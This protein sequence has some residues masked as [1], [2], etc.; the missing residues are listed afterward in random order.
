MEYKL[1]Y[2]KINI[3]P[4]SI[5]KLNNAEL[6]KNNIMYYP[7]KLTMESATRLFQNAINVEM[8]DK[9][10]DSVGG[11]WTIEGKNN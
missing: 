5:L 10:I 6:L 11:L 4:T 9:V 8:C 2:E 1:N 7:K 3:D